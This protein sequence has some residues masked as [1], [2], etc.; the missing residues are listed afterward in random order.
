MLRPRCRL[1]PT[2]PISVCS[3]LLHIVSTSSELLPSKAGAL[4]PR[5]LAQV[6]IA[7]GP[8]ER[9]AQQRGAHVNAQQRQEDNGP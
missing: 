8:A 7:L 9:G 6:A 5:V 1:R 3:T 4:R 2:L